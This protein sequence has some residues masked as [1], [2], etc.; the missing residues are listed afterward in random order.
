[1]GAGRKAKKPHAPGIRIST[2]AKAEQALDA[3]ARLPGGAD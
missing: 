1:M 2:E 3:D